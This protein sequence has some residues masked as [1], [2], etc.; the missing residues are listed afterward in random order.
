M[1]PRFPFFYRGNLEKTQIRRV[2]IFPLTCQ[3][4]LSK[5]NV[6]SIFMV[7]SCEFYTTYPIFPSLPY[8]NHYFNGH[9]CLS[10]HRSSVCHKKN[11]LLNRLGIPLRPPRSTPWVDPGHN[12]EGYCM[13]ISFIEDLFILRWSFF[14]ALQG[15]HMLNLNLKILL[16]KFSNLN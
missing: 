11:F 15:D 5:Q 16:A 2:K 3:E 7:F 12:P 9:V 1:F 13:H 14:R 6:F 4:Q 10:V 8:L